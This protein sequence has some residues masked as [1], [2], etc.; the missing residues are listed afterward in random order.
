M[1]KKN[2]P[3][4]KNRYTKLLILKSRRFKISLSLV[5]LILGYIALLTSKYG[6]GLPWPLLSIP[7]II[8]G[9]LTLFVPQSEQWEYK[10]WQ[11]RPER[12]EK[13]TFE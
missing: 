9:L 4:D 11:D 8:I 6:E 2:I 3:L 13:I 5:F 7:I 10:Y 1:P 12:Y